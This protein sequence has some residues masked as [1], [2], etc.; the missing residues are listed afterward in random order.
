MFSELNQ[1]YNVRELRYYIE[2]MNSLG[3]IKAKKLVEAL[4]G[5]INSSKRALDIIKYLETIE[6]KSRKYIKKLSLKT[7]AYI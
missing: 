4:E 7:I 6:D 5:V 2:F 3:N 1:N